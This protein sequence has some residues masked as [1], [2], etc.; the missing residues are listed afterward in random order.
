MNTKEYYNIIKKVSALFPN[1]ISDE[2]HQESSVYT[3]QKKKKTVQ[4]CIHISIE[5]VKGVIHNIIPL[6]SEEILP[7]K[8]SFFY[9]S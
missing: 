9:E 2:S 1:H 6:H 8:L 3:R 5:Y 7:K 4:I